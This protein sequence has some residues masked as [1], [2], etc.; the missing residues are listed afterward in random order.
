MTEKDKGYVFTY[1]AA[2]KK[3]LQNAMRH[4]PET[5]T[6]G[7]VLAARVGKILQAP[8]A[9]RRDIRE[10][11]RRHAADVAARRNAP[12]ET[13]DAPVRTTPQAKRD[14]SA[15]QIEKLMLDGRD[16]R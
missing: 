4:S 3:R 10:S 8:F 7:G 2:L 6:E 12:R 14:I 15:R 5:A 13:D 1:G 16:V 9:A 11:I